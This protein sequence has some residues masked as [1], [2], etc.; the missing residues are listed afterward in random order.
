MNIA[1]QNSTTQIKGY[2]TS[3]KSSSGDAGIRDTHAGSVESTPAWFGGK[4]LK[5]LGALLLATAALT[6]CKDPNQV[7]QAH[8][9]PVKMEN[10]ATP[11]KQPQAPAAAPVPAPK[12]GC[13][14]L[15]ELKSQAAPED[16]SLLKSYNLNVDS[17]RTSCDMEN[18]QKQT[19]ALERQ[20]RAL[21]AQARAQEA[22]AAAQ[23]RQ[24]DAA[25][26]QAD[27][28]KHQQDMQNAE[29][30]GQAIGV[31]GD[32]LFQGLNQILR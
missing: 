17:A 13:Q 18:T 20:T 31:V 29:A 9:E 8:H 2:S 5:P 27:Y 15:L 10:P 6:G 11:V 32:A 19:E 14:Q 22:Q 28:F 4:F 1:A 3:S 26:R 30:A 12:T 24:A 23:Q 21:E 16:P 25:K 7:S